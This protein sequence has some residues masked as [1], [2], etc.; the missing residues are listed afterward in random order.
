[1]RTDPEPDEII[2]I[3]DGNGA[4]IYTDPGRPIFASI[5]E[6]QRW[7]LGVG[8]EKS[9]GFVSQLLITF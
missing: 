9:E 7:V 4:H 1:M 2:A 5:L 3:S 6:M 8:F